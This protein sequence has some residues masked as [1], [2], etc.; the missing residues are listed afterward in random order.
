MSRRVAK[1]LIALVLVAAVAAVYF[2][3]LRDHLNREEIRGFVA[4]LRGVW[5]GPIAFI[6]IFAVGCVFALPATIFVLAAGVI[7]GWAFG[8]TY[9]IIGGLIGAVASFYVG[10][11]IGEGML[12][13]FG[14]LGKIVGKQ[15]DHAGFKSLLILR[16]VPGLP[17]PVL[18]YGAGVCGVKVSDFVAATLLGMAPSIYVFSY[19]ADALFNGTM[20]EGEAVR[21]LIIVA[22]LMIGIVLI[23]GLLKRRMAQAAQPKP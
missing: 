15:V 12:T 18:N 11:F 1:G 3:P 5:Y 16:F 20:S 4:Q 8:G 2:S 21:R 17:F 9:S 13:R 14:R 10:R 23:P 7:W 22:I 19:C 6:A